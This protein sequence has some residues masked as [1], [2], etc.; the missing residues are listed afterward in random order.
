M[1]GL[2]IDDQV[3]APSI[4]VGRVIPRGPS[5][6]RD[7]RRVEC[8][9]RCTIGGKEIEA[10][11][12]SIFG[13]SPVDVAE[14]LLVKAKLP[15]GFEAQELGRG[16]ASVATSGCVVN[17]LI[18]V[19]S[20]A[21]ETVGPLIREIESWIDESGA[22]RPKNAQA[23]AESTWANGQCLLA[24]CR[25]PRSLSDPSSVSRLANR[26][27][28]QRNTSTGW[29][30]RPGMP[31]T[32]DPIFAVYPVLSLMAASAA[33]LVDQGTID[34]LRDEGLRLLEWFKASGRPL[35]GRLVAL[36]LIHMLYRRGYLDDAA[37]AKTIEMGSVALQQELWSDGR[38][39]LDEPTITDDNQ[40]IWYARLFRPAFYLFAR[41]LWPVAHPVPTLLAEELRQRFDL[42]RH[43]WG[44]TGGP[45]LSW[46]TAL[47]LSSG[48][49]LSHDVLAS[50][51]GLDAWR[52]RVAQLLPPVLPSFDYDVVVSFSGRQRNVAAEINRVLKA[53]GLVTFYDHDHEHELLGEDL[54]VALQR[55]YFSRSRYAV[56]IL[57]H[58]FL[59][60]KWAGNW[61]WKAILAA[62]Q[63]RRSSYLLPYFWEELELPGLN[64]SIGY[65]SRKRATPEQFAQVVVRKLRSSH[66]P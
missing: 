24:L 46:A 10:I 28:G 9:R 36:A 13:A 39:H 63:A 12:T 56:A 19:P 48:L 5:F 21:A 59:E 34:T 17:A 66:S 51:L 25:Q 31:G 38:L 2:A 47:G 55:I 44:H 26:L 11:F 45:P 4:G 65:I 16:Q 29:P 14:T 27:T 23:R 57:S 30:L 43:A 49:Q 52:D 1:A 6:H 37:L 33:R 41:R 35:H 62:M 20:M 3:S 15:V 40:P 58:D 42:D 7:N 64:P 8:L 61:E 22:L 54:T 32:G 60:S 18:N 50:E 53:A